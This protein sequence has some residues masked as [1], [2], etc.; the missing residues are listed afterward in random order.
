MSEKGNEVDGSASFE[1]DISA[2]DLVEKYGIEDDVA[3]RIVADLPDLAK[4]W[5]TIPEDEEDITPPGATQPPVPT[6]YPAG[7]KKRKLTAYQ[8]NILTL[9]KRA[10]VPE[11]LITNVM[12]AISVDE[13]VA[14]ADVMEPIS[15]DKEFMK[16]LKRILRR[17]KLP[18][19]W[20]ASVMEPISVDE[21]TWSEIFVPESDVMEPISVDKEFRTLLLRILRRAKIPKEWRIRVMEPI[22]VDEADVMEPISVDK[23]MKRIKALKLPKDIEAKVM[24]AISVDEA[25][26]PRSEAQRAMA[27]FKISVKEWNALSKEKKEEFIKKLPARGTAGAKGSTPTR[28]PWGGI[29][30]EDTPLEG[31]TEL[32][33]TDEQKVKLTEMGLG[34]IAKAQ[35]IWFGK[36]PD[37]PDIGSMGG[38]YPG[39]GAAD[40]AFFD[41]L[42]IT[43]VKDSVNFE[44]GVLKA[45]AVCTAAMVQDYNGTKILKCPDELKLAVDFV[46]Q[47]PI[48]DGHP[49]GALVRDQKEIKGWTGPLTYDAE[50]QRIECDVEI[51][52][53]AL[54]EKIQNGMT[55][56][57]IG[58]FCDLDHKKGTFKDVEGKVAEYDAVQRNFVLNHLATGVGQ[59]RCPEGVCG[60]GQ[61]SINAD[62]DVGTHEK[63]LKEKVDALKALGDELS[64]KASTMKPE[65]IQAKCSQMSDIAWKVRE[66]T[67]VI[68]V[69]KIGVPDDIKESTKTALDAA[70]AIIK[71][72][73][74]DAHEYNMA[75]DF[76]EKEKATII[77][78]IMDLEP[79]KPRSYFDSMNIVALK[80]L[81]A[82]M[83]SV[84]E[85]DGIDYSKS[86]KVGQDAVDKVYD[87]LFGQ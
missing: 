25:D 5:L 10:K 15:V 46:K 36:L 72:T 11:E 79:P 60:I 31:I 34:P 9:L 68:N 74:A 45:H 2:Q 52:D 40:G 65:E 41:S 55:D 71:D 86:K 84:K 30:A 53:S 78:S 39:P 66:M 85:I 57:S 51:T 56:V 19:K 32:E 18:K 12:E 37:E 73:K 49:P 77:D 23:L 1:I 3:E 59:G 62:V 29:S 69:K 28:I 42:D 38:K 70:E 35:G 48:T 82:L 50:K 6:G 4:D 7:E 47:L 26:Q 43:F 8:E 27:H 81:K 17:A 44:D 58:F 61:D 13:V 80:D 14:L 22:S 64:A 54:I 83:D 20:E 16:T 76:M 67:D 21:I 63:L 24:E 33:L 87:D 75:L